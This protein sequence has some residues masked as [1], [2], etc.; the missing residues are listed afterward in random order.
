[1]AAP[2]DPLNPSA[3]PLAQALLDSL[4]IHEHQWHRLK[5][6][7]HH[8][9]AEQAAAGLN[10]LLHGQEQAALASLQTAVAWLKGE[11]RDPGCPDR[12]KPPSTIRTAG[13]DGRVVK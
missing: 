1:M 5:G 6:S 4:R 12:G 10:Q 13:H 9:A 2:T 8:R 7:A 3:I 11:L